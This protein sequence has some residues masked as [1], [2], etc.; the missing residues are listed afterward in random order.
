[1]A[2]TLR[3]EYEGACYHVINRGNYR[4]AIFASDGAAEAFER[5]LNE[6]AERFGWGDPRVCDHEQSFSFGGRDAAAEFERRDEAPAGYVGQSIQ[7]VPR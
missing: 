5:A 2:R 1:M 6:P 4:R 3:L 7:S